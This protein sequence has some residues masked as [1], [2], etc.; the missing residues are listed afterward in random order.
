VRAAEPAYAED[1]AV[2]LREVTFQKRHVTT[3]PSAPP[4]IGSADC[5]FG[6][7]RNK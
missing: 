2:Q 3:V 5:S 6:G 4:S 1:G 7:V